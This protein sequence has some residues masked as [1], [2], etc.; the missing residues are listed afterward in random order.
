MSLLAIPSIALTSADILH[1]VSFL[2]AAVDNPEIG[3]LPNVETISIIRDLLR[4]SSAL[5]LGDVLACL[6]RSRATDPR[7]M[8]YGLLGLLPKPAIQPDYSNASTRD[9]YIALVE[10]C[11]RTERSLDIITLSRRSHSSTTPHLPSWAPDWTE[12]YER[13]SWEEKALMNEDLPPY[14]LVVKYFGGEY[15]GSLT[16]IDSAEPV[17]NSAG[18]LRVLASWSADGDCPPIAS[19]KEISPEA[20]SLTVRGITIGRIAKLGTFTNYDEDDDGRLFFF[21][22]LSNWEELMLQRF[23]LCEDAESGRTVLDVFDRCLQILDD[24]LISTGTEFTAER[25]SKFRK[26]DQHRGE[27]ERLYKYTK[28]S[29]DA[30]ESHSNYRHKLSPCDT[31]EAFTRTI[32]ADLDSDL[33]RLPSEPSSLNSLFFRPTDASTTSTIP[34]PKSAPS[35]SPPVPAPAISP[36]LPFATNRRFFITSDSHIG[37]APIKA[38]IDDHVCVIYG[39]CVPVVLREAEGGNFTFVGE[40]YAHG[41]MDGEAVKG[42]E[43][44]EVMEREW[45]IL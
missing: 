39:C 28:P 1:E 18:T 16:L 42:V 23:G 44:G 45:D 30:G 22:A 8:V 12:T 13:G 10:Q 26:R 5:F 31:V 41:F 9:V 35:T 32:L 43:E 33:Q 21:H 3:W 14:P 37:L 25:E 38:R 7:D 19:T 17:L 15:L 4:V 24:H 40:A 6:R 36:F 2:A 20:T 27:R 34:D 29:C 11:I